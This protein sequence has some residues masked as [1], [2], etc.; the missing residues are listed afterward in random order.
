MLP[1][2]ADPGP[3]AG[4]RV[5]GYHEPTSRGPGE[6]LDKLPNRGTKP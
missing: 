4:A 3:V 5:L 1:T 6:H 2:G